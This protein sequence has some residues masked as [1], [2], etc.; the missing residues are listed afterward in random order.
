MIVIY[1]IW[2]PQMITTVYICYNLSIQNSA[3]RC[4]WRW[5]DVFGI[6]CDLITDFWTFLEINWKHGCHRCFLWSMTWQVAG[7]L[8]LPAEHKMYPASEEK[9]RTKVQL[10]FHWLIVK[11]SLA[12]STDFLLKNTAE[13]SFGNAQRTGRGSQPKPFAGMVP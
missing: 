7:F 9:G 10:V 4:D 2:I 6:F 13:R 12:R 5:Q 1:P 3:G 11:L 8:Y